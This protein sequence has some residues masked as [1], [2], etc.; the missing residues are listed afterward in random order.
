MLGLFDSSAALAAVPASEEG[1]RQ[2]TPPRLVHDF[3]FDIARI[4]QLLAKLLDRRESFSR[5]ASKSGSSI[6]SSSSSTS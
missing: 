6:P 4:R 2:K 1:N 3:E 5:A